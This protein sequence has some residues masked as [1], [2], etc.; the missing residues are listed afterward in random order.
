MIPQPA[1]SSRNHGLYFDDDDDDS[2]LEDTQHPPVLNASTTTTSATTTTDR[3]GTVPT[4]P[5]NNFNEDED[6]AAIAAQYSKHSGKDGIETKRRK[7]ERPKITIERMIDPEYGLL[8]IITNIPRN[9]GK[10][11]NWKSLSIPSTTAKDAAAVGCTA[12]ATTS[13]VRAKKIDQAAQYMNT[14]LQSYND[15]IM[16]DW[17]SLPSS[18]MHGSAQQ[19]QVV[20]KDVFHKIAALGSKLPLKDHLNSLRHE[21]GR[22][23][24]VQTTLSNEQRATKLLQQYDQYTYQQQEQQQEPEQLYR[25]EEDGTMVQELPP[26]PRV[27]GHHEDTPPPTA[28][29]PP[30]DPPE[31]IVASHSSWSVPENDPPDG[32]SSSSTL[33]R[34]NHKNAQNDEL[35]TSSSSSAATTI[36]A[37]KRR[38][39][40]E[41]SEEE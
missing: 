2:S 5:S 18:N 40:L 37:N 25:P 19:Q 3:T 32:G 31:E 41:D 27:R 21:M 6:D 34:A 17:L 39:I 38:Y 33:D 13:N 14:V 11:Q 23:P 16:N 26:Q 20:M 4:R 30:H 8:R 28:P 15:I 1:A 36:P 24:Y 29:P 12:A 22:N 7:I 35:P 10:L 9:V